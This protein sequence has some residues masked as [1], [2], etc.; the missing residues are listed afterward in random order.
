MLRL[1][2][3]RD[4]RVLPESTLV[5]ETSGFPPLDSAAV[6][7]S[8]ALRFVPAKTGG[9]A[10]DASVLFPVLFR[11][12]DAPPLPGDTMLQPRSP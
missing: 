4:G 3:T 1:F 12:P 2:I 10:R 7:G 6:R 5:V 8:E 9:E 11:H